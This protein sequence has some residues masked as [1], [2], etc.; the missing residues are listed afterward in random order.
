[1]DRASERLIPPTIVDYPLRTERTMPFELPVRR[2]I[3]DSLHSSTSWAA[4][5]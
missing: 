5:V 1:M 2:V 3:V 4:R